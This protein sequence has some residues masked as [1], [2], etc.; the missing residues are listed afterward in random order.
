MLLNFNK[1]WM[2]A[3]LLKKIES[4]LSELCFINQ[5]LSLKWV[6][7]KPLLLF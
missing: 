4:N 2:V 5:K 7:H 1:C 3:S 6:L